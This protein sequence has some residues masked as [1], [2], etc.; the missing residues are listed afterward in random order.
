PS[1]WASPVNVELTTVAVALL[2][3]PPPLFSDKLP[4]N[5][6]LPTVRMPEPLLLMP[7]PYTARFRWNRL[8]LMVSVP[9][10]WRAPPPAAPPPTPI[11]TL[12]ENVEAVMFVVPVAKIAPP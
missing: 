7:P 5:V 6:V 9:M 12:F 11:T 4:E 1:G 8:R 2:L 10:L 3:M